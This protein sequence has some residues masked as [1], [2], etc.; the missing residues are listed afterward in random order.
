MQNTTESTLTKTV[1]ESARTLTGAS[2]DYDPL[3]DRVGDAR[4]ILI[5]EAS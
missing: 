4:F 3:I 1:R 5:G 2:P